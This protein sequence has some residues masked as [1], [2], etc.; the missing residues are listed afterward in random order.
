[1]DVQNGSKESANCI[2]KVWKVNNGLDVTTSNTNQLPS[3]NNDV[4]EW[5]KLIH[6]LELGQLT[7]SCNN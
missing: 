7:L 2:P 1:M 6:D 3:D 4:Q 5:H